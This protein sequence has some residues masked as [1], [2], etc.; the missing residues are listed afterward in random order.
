MNLDALELLL[1]SNFLKILR[2]FAFLEATTAKRMKVDPA[3]PSATELLRTESTFQRGRPI[4]YVDIAGRSSARSLQ[5]KQS[6]QN[7]K[8]VVHLPLR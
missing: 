1:S 6:E 7:V 3:I 5:S 8:A 2:Y 4:V